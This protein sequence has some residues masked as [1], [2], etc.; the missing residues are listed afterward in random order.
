MLKKIFILLLISPIFIWYS[1]N[2]T[3][4][5][6]KTIYPIQALVKHA[7]VKNVRWIDNQYLQISSFEST[8]F[9]T[10]NQKTVFEFHPYTNL[11]NNSQQCKYGITVL[12]DKSCPQ[13]E[14]ELKQAKNTL[15]KIRDADKSLAEKAALP[16]VQPSAEKQDLTLLVT[17]GL[18][19][20]SY[21]L[22]RKTSILEKNSKF[23]GGHDRQADK[24]YFYFV[25]SK[26]NPFS[27]E[28]TEIPTINISR[29]NLTPKQQE[30]LKEIEEIRQRA[31]EG[32]RKF[33]EKIAESGN[34]REKIH[35]IFLEY[36][37]PT[38]WIADTALKTVEKIEMPRPPWMKTTRS[39][40]PF[41][42]CDPECFD[43]V[44]YKAVNDQIYAF[45]HGKSFQR[46]KLG[47]YRFNR[48]DN[49]WQQIVSGPVAASGDISPNGCSF[50][51]I[52]DDQVEMVNLCAEE[53]AGEAV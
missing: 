15:I 51:Y 26:S 41:M 7:D 19:Q 52:Q 8:I 3:F 32:Q 22:D 18:N 40:F 16:R 20:P 37:K 14:T 1:F 48:S 27:Y 50:A 2:P 30:T 9:D 49:I 33:E 53:K 47:V 24:I 25:P 12:S 28:R 17:L 6:V 13:I 35:Q 44:K 10:Y 34:S 31:I 45:V 46:R 29:E 21:A 4:D 39:N 5:R 38:I 42:S 36:R 43:S 11:Q 23:I